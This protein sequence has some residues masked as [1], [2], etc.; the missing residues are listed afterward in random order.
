MSCIHNIDGV[1]VNGDCPYRADYCP[2]EQD[3]SICR[4]RQGLSGNN[5]EKQ[6]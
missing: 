2:V 6:K 5:T 1:C 3:D 4:Y